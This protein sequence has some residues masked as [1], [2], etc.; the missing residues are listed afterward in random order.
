MWG[1]GD[2]IYKEPPAPDQ[3]WVTLPEISGLG[4]EPRWDALKEFEEK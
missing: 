1:I 2:K 3:G 4:L